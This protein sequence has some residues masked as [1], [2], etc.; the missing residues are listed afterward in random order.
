MAVKI[1]QCCYTNASRTENNIQKTGWQAVAVSEGIPAEAYGL[2]TRSQGGNSAINGNMQDET[3]N[4]LNLYEI[5]SDGQYVCV[6]RSKY[7]LQDHA[8]R[9]N[10]FSQA[11]I[12]PWTEDVVENPNSFL[13]KR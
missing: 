6:M 1:W 9:A 8:G 13:G 12:L 5:F 2:C 3:G 7:G 4:I 10:M 11:F